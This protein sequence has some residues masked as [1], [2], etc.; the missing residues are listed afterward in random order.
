M[1]H[2]GGQPSFVDCLFEDNG[3]S[4]PISCEF[5]TTLRISKCKFQKNV[6]TFSAGVIGSG[7][8]R[9]EISE[10]TFIGNR[11]ALRGGALS[12][13]GTELYVARCSF[14]GNHAGE[15]GGAVMGFSAYGVFVDCIFSGNSAGE[16]GGAVS[17]GIGGVTGSP[18]FANCTFSA[19]T[20][21]GYGGGL[22]NSTADGT[23]ISNSILW[24]NADGYGT[25]ESAQLYIASSAAVQPPE[26]TCIQGLSGALGVANIG[27]D[28][29]FVDA[30]GAD[31]IAGTF[32]DDLR[33]SPGSP[34]IDAA[35]NLHVPPDLADLD[36]DG[37]ASEST[38]FD[39]AGNTRFF[40]IPE[41]ID[42]GNGIAPIVDMGAYETVT[43]CNNNRVL[44]AV[45]IATGTSRDCDHN[46]VPDECDVPAKDCNRNGVEDVCESDSDGDGVINPCDPCPS[47]ALNDVDGDGLCANVDS[48]P[49]VFNPDQADRD[50]D[51]IGDACAGPI[52]AVSGW[53]LL[54]LSLLILTQSKLSRR[55]GV[56]INP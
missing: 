47:D 42:T 33:L 36:G 23:W 39:L 13:G 9:L 56:P 55:S 37:D 48:C 54:V 14:F 35:F 49:G 32:D 34:C 27:S 50:G 2:E 46:D 6:G 24:G 30:D 16:N 43:D 5:A 18:S 45:D 1:L 21:T 7:A 4:E 28:P 26:Y 11:T 17:V 8:G 52:P 10:S 25:G 15:S 51:G 29:M 20:A 53:A 19:N 38:P 3:Y 40:D 12:A 41:T 31:D 22:Y 44:D